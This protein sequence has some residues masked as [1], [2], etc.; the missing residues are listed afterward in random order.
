MAG[1]DDVYVN[2]TKPGTEDRSLLLARRGEACQRHRDSEPTAMDIPTRREQQVIT[3]SL[4][5]HLVRG[6]PIE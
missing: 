1:D 5:P 4:L 3:V 6:F 2:K